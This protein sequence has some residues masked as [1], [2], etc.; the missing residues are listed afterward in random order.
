MSITVQINGFPQWKRNIIIPYSFVQ[1]LTVTDM[2]MR[3]IQTPI[4]FYSYSNNCLIENL[5][6]IKK[7][8][9]LYV[10]RNEFEKYL[11]NFAIDHN[12][13]IINNAY[14]N[15]PNY[16][17]TIDTMFPDIR[18]PQH[19]QLERLSYL[20]NT[21]NNYKKKTIF[22]HITGKDKLNVNNIEK[23][24]MMNMS[25]KNIYKIDYLYLIPESYDLIMIIH[26]IKKNI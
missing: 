8:D 16:Y 17:C 3:L 12:Y 1:L 14:W 22:S 15:C 23:L 6:Q 11:Y 25:E 21:G 20:Y 5:E 19:P 7:R 24:T 13:N 4:C 2:A 18:N 26:E 10:V 9:L